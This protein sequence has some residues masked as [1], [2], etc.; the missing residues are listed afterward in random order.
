MSRITRPRIIDGQTVD[1]TDLNSRFTDYSQP[2][3]L[4]AF[5]VRDAA[6]DLGHL[7]RTSF[8]LEQM[9]QTII[10]NNDW[11]HSTFN[12]VSGQ[13][14]TPAAPHIVSD[15]GGTPTPLSL[16]SGWALN[17]DNILRVYWDLSVKPYYTGTRPWASVGALSNYIF[18][19]GSGSGTHDIA[20]GVTCWPF[21][22][23]WD[24]TDATLTN[25]VNVTGQSDF[26][27]GVSTYF[28]NQLSQCE[29]TSVVN[30]FLETAGGPV[31]GTIN[32]RLTVDVGWTSVS[33]AWH[34]KE[35]LGTT[36][37]YGLRVVFTGVCHSLNNAG[38]NWLVRDDPVSPSARL[39]YNGG[40]LSAMVVRIK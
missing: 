9:D 38:V 2:A 18:P 4:N 15:G 40:S 13:T 37:V 27:N 16:G 31:N 3:A 33:G 10:G 26:N 22:L 11:K 21:W 14:G 19:H 23:Q 7:K 25:W 1:A 34:Y 28:G 8:Q 6:V 30:A 36:T 35:G 12:T 5:N 39:D 20:T 32:T 29:S 24:I 17:A